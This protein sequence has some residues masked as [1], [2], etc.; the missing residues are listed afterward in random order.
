MFNSWMFNQKPINGVFRVPATPKRLSVPQF[1]EVRDI[2]GN[3]VALLSPKSDGLKNCWIDDEQNGSCTLEFELPLD[4][5]KWQYLTDQYRIY[6]GGKEFVI[7]NP[8]AVDK[9]RDGKK[10]KG[11]VKAHESWVL[12]GKKYQTICNDPLIGTPPWGAVIIVSGGTA[13]GGF[14]PGSAGSA[15]SYL[16]QGTGWTVGTVDVTG[17]YDLETEKESVLYNINQVQEKW[18]GILIWDSIN[19]TVSLRDE[20]TYKPYTEIGRAHV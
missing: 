20:A 4:N 16:L 10:L 19:K 8:D 5:P 7:L 3:T 1:I 11:K 17:T 2:E 13:H 12:L 18:G 9:Q 14:D 6:A 15:L